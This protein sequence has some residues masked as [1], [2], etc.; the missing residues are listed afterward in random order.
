MFSTVAGRMPPK[1]NK[2]DEERT[3]IA[4]NKR[5]RHDYHI[6]ETLEAGLVLT[7]TEVK[8]LRNGRANLVDAYGIVKGGE[9]FLL[10]M[11]VSPYD[12][13]KVSLVL[14]DEDRA[15]GFFEEAY[16]QRSSGLIF[17]RSVRGCVR[18]TSR[19]DSLVNKLHFQG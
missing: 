12:M 6:L 1:S 5:A 17:L 13:G 18:N 4:R 10:N 11:H 9:V 15:L 7:G 16:R 2:Q 3:V 19:F 14:G 8:S